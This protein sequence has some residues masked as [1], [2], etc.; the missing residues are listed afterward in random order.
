MI[1]TTGLG[2]VAAKTFWKTLPDTWEE[3][4]PVF[5]AI[6]TAILLQRIVA[7]LFKRSEQKQEL[8]GRGYSLIKHSIY[9]IIYLSALIVVIYNIPPFRQIALSLL[10]SAGILAVILGFAAQH[11]FTN[12]VSGVF[13]ILFK[14][15]KVGDII[16]LSD[17]L[18][19]VVEDITLR[20]T[21]IRNF[22]NRRIMVPNAEMSKEIIVNSDIRDARI[23]KHYNI[24]IAFDA[25]VEKA[26]QI[27]QEEAT[28]HPLCIDNRTEE[29]IKNNEPIVEIKLIGFNNYALNIRAWVW[30]IDA[31]TA[32]D[33]ACSL[34]VI[35][36]KRFDEANIQLALP[37][38][39][40]S[41]SNTNTT[42]T[43][44]IQ[45]L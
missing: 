33:L 28:K 6:I 14:P 17:H 30:A 44:L 18:I 9:V 10:A 20:H 19:G 23:R 16:E 12:I 43:S 24:N 36:K 39:I 40:I 31:E 29:Q 25:D 34:N 4:M 1:K 21:V 41:S 11:A 3:W 13:I 38:Y 26:M 37:H 8:R 22:E 5:V 27:I 42:L 2:I 35:I 45:K 7:Y 15:F 32:F